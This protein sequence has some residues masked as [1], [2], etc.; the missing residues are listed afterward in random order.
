M[1]FRLAHRMPISLF[2]VLT[3]GCVL[4]GLVIGLACLKQPKDFREPFE[5]DLLDEG[6]AELEPSDQWAEGKRRRITWGKGYRLTWPWP[7]L[8]VPMVAL[9]TAIHLAA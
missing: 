9:F 7:W 2:E 4:C 5:A 1:L 8:V 3:A 6:P